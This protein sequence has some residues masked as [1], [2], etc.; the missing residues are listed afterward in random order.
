MS[1]VGK[2]LTEQIG[3][4]CSRNPAKAK[5]TK[6]EGEEYAREWE[7]Q[8]PKPRGQAEGKKEASVVLGRHEVLGLCELQ[9]WDKTSYLGA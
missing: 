8:V 5:N 1:Q 4:Q 6:I 7:Q 9:S 3:N 2:G